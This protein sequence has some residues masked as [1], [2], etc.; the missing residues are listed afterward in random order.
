MVTLDQ[1]HS[2]NHIQAHIG[3]NVEIRCDIVSKPRQP[4]IKWSRYNVDLGSL[5]TPNIKVFNDGSIYLANV[6]LSLSGNYTCHAEYNLIVKQVHV[7]QV[8]GNNWLKL[9]LNIL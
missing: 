9:I 2:V 4:V 1:A 3:D 7:L 6:Q 5:Q 8:I